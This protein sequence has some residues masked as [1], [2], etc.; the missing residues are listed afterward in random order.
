MLDTIQ[1][2]I[3]EEINNFG[4]YSVCGDDLVYAAAAAILWF[5]SADQET[6]AH[7]LEHAEIHRESLQK[8]ESMAFLRVSPDTS[9]TT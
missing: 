6:R 7:L 4:D 5:N 2:A 3:V 1:A 8:A 9:P